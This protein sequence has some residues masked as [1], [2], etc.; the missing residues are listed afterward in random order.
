MQ[1]VR[2]GGKK[3]VEEDEGLA[4]ERR[5]S[6]LGGVCGHPVSCPDLWLPALGIIGT[7]GSL[8][9]LST[10]SSSTFH[11]SLTSPAH[12]YLQWDVTTIIMLTVN[13][14]EI[15]TYNYC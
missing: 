9:L 14:A 15:T 3:E 7:K 11:Q 13:P 2:E 12:D 4:G 1:E 8:D 6:Q 5:R 10:P